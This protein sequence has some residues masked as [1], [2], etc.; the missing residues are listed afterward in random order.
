MVETAPPVQEPPKPRFE[1]VVVK[2]DSVIGIR[3]DQEVSSGTARL[4]DRITAKIVRDVAVDGRTALPAGTRLE[5]VVTLV[6]RGGKMRTRAKLGIRFNMLVLA[7]G[8]RVPIQ[9]EA[10]LREG[11]SPSNEATSKIGAGAVAGAIVGGLLGGKRGAVVGSTV[12]A[13]GGTAAVMTSGRNEVTLASGAPLTVR[14]TAP[15]TITIEKDL[16]VR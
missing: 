13:A 15:V 14:L 8:L 2:E 10:I 12:G 6:E 5:G 4:E 3:I 9:T 16:Q 7:D 1:E 11:E